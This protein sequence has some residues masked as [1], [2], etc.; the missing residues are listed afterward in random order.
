ML[1]L[2]VHRVLVMLF[3]FLAVIL[4]L[5][6]YWPAA[7]VFYIAFGF[8]LSDLR[9]I[10]RSLFPQSDTANQPNGKWQ[11]YNKSL[12]PIDRHLKNIRTAKKP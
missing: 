4:S 1:N 5:S 7:T 10:A 11:I 3:F 2:I 8:G 6:G 12:K 9:V